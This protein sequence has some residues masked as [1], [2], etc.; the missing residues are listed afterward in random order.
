LRGANAQLFGAVTWLALDKNNLDSG[1]REQ[2]RREAKQISLGE[3]IPLFMELYAKPKNRSWEASQ[4][5][6]GAFQ[7]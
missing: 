1:C 5:L 4:R 2:K 3:V 7:H 6:L